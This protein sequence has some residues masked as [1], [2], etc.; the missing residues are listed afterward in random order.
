MKTPPVITKVTWQIASG[1]AN[2]TEKYDAGL[3]KYADFDTAAGREFSERQ[4]RT[5]LARKAKSDEKFLRL[6]GVMSKFIIDGG[7]WG[8]GTKDPSKVGSSPYS[9]TGKEAPP[10]SSSIEGTAIRK[11]PNCRN[12]KIKLGGWDKLADMF[13]M[14]LKEAPILEFE[15]WMNRN[16]NKYLISEVKALL[17]HRPKSEQDMGDPV[18][19]WGTAERLMNSWVYIIVSMGRVLPQW[20]RHESLSRVV[21]TAKAVKA[22][23]RDKPTNLDYKRVY[24]PK[25]TAPGTTTATSWRPLGVPTLPW[26]VYLHM[27]N[28]IMSIYLENLLPDSQHGFRPKKGTLTAWR[29]VLE[30][31]VNK[32]NIWEFD[33][34]QF[35][36]TVDL[37]AL[38]QQMQRYEFPWSMSQQF[39]K[40]H[41]CH[42]TLPEIERVNEDHTRYGDPG[43]PWVMGR[44]GNKIYDGLHP[45]ALW[46]QGPPGSLRR[47]LC[48]VPQGAP[49]SPLLS[50]ILLTHS[51]M[52]GSPHTKMYADDGVYASDKKL[53][54]P[55]P[56]LYNSEYGINFHP[57]K[58]HWVKK[59]G[60]WLK[61]LK[62]LGLVYNGVTDTLSAAT[63]KGS[64]IEVP[65]FVKDRIDYYK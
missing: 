43:G 27:H 30:N 4:K 15:P 65:Q 50:L 6:A 54:I 40:I 28:N 55:A 23:S 2:K 34:K 57:D 60:K 59:D 21:A 48:G 17:K 45:K 62:F 64:T 12:F 8:P 7:T 13:G 18:K 35:F 22:M 5:A 53:R 39:Y 63:R 26:R 24:I 46:T 52:T 33:L 49:T 11:L 38:K 20:H 51:V 25:G 37:V 42:P 10:Y 31:V 61:P 32:Q 9:S 44:T 47:P 41:Q 14:K 3:A 58:C 1:P 56:H 16:M 36:D 29:D 19:F